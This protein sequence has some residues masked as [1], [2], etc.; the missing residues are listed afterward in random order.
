MKKVIAVLLVFSAL[1][2]V[3]ACSFKSKI[4][5]DPDEYSK[6]VSEEQ[7]KKEVEESE[8]ADDISEAKSETEDKIGVTEEGKQIVVKLYGGTTITYEK[9]VFD[10]KGT[11]DYRIEYVYYDTEKH[12]K[13][14]KEFGD[15]DNKKLI[16]SDDRTLCLTYKTTEGLIKL[17]YATALSLYERRNEEFC[18]IVY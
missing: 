3:S 6:A 18:E 1:L 5:T 7:S 9:S 8:R 14:I 15:Y 12:Y 16:E 13:D 17:D 11:L 2:S 4:Y 10:K